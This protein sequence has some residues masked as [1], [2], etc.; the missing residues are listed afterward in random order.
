MLPSH[1]LLADMDGRF[2]AEALRSA[3]TYLDDLCT[4]VSMFLKVLVRWLCCYPTSGTTVC[5]AFCELFNLL[6]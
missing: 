5:W 2:L 6:V 1:D 4:D 3:Y